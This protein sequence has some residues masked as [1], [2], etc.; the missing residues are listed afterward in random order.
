MTKAVAAILTL[1]DITDDTPLRLD[2]AA[3]LAFPGGGSIR[4]S[5]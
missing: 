4:A 5:A 3:V 1:V 2:K